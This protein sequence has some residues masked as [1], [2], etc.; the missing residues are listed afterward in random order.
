MI[1]ISF[2]LEVLRERGLITAEELEEISS[3][4][5]LS[6]LFE[7]KLKFVASEEEIAYVMEVKRLLGEENL[8]A[9][10][11]VTPPLGFINYHETLLRV[12]NK[13]RKK[14]KNELCG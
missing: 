14:E 13:I 12:L 1:I 6:I 4:Y 5:T 8:D 3:L 11:K 9:V 2:F 10:F 7:K